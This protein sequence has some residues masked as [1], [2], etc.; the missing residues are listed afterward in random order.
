MCFLMTRGR[1]IFTGIQR[2]GNG[3]QSINFVVHYNFRRSSLISPLFLLIDSSYILDYEIAHHNEVYP[4][5][6]L[7]GGNREFV[8]WG[9]AWWDSGKCQ[10]A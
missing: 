6:V 2:Q 4:G 7:W 9:M 8:E 10:F 3:K 1:I 5:D